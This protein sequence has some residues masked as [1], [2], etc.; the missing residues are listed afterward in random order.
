MLW[1]TKPVP[2]VNAGSNGG[3]SYPDLAAMC[4]SVDPT[5]KQYTPLLSLTGLKLDPRKPVEIDDLAASES[6]VPAVVINPQDP[7]IEITGA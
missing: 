5:A 1:Q 4:Q 6:H 7:A 3:C 2:D